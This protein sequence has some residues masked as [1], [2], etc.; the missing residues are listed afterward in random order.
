MV[1]F[2]CAATPH[3]EVKTET[4]RGSRPPLPRPSKGKISRQHSKKGPKKQL[5]LLLLLLCLVSLS[6]CQRRRTSQ[7][8]RRMPMPP[9]ARPHG[10]E[11]QSRQVFGWPQTKMWRDSNYTVEVGLSPARCETSDA[12][13]RLLRIIRKKKCGR[14]E[15]YL[16]VSSLA[17]S[18][19]ELAHSMSSLSNVTRPL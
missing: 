3:P 16:T 11:H 12:E 1:A 8:Q 17:E 6:R 2:C 9:A 5:M 19:S 13:T 7:Q 4:G 18:G 10:R 15:G 14:V